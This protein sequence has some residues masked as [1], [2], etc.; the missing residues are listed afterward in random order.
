[1]D[2]GTISLIG[3]F[4]TAIISV[5]SFVRSGS[6]KTSAESREMGRFEQKLDTI[7]ADVK[8]IK[9][10]NLDTAKL[11]SLTTER[12]DTLFKWKDRIEERVEKL[13]RE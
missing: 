6:T 13:E 2:T 3:M 1:M 8:E 7:S 4:I 10:Q 11:E 9:R 5:A 12:L